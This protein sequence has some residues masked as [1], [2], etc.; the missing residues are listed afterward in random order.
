MFSYINRVFFL[1]WLFF[2]F[3]YKKNENERIFWS[4][5]SFINAWSAHYF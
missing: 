3:W 4:K 1:I 5:F 2:A